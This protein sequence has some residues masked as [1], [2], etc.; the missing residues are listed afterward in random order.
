VPLKPDEA[1]NELIVRCRKGDRA[2]QKTLFDTYKK[3]MFT[4]AYRIVNDSDHAHDV[5][6]EAFLEVFR[7][8]GQFRGTSTLGA[9]I[10]TI[11]YPESLV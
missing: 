3:A 9:W 10:K 5:L 6:Q 4:K 7:D 1:Q 8:I 11:V 2:A